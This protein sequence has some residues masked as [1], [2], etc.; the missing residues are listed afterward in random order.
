MTRTL[1]NPTCSANKK[2]YQTLSFRYA[3]S[4]S[5]NFRWCTCG[6]GQVHAGGVEQPIITCL[7]CDR[8]SCFHH[9]GAWHENLTCDE[10]DALLADPVNFRSRFDLENEAAEQEAAKRRAQ[11]DA[12]RAYAQSLVAREERAEAQARK[13]QARLREQ[14][15]K[16]EAAEQERKRAADA[17]I[18]EAARRRAE[19]DQSL[20][21]VERTSKPC[22]GCGWAIEKNEGW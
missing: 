6:Y 20:R 22:P 12:D 16:E 8:R 1:S 10:Y 17:A 14:Q 4:E 21:L 3:I 11:E 13:E 7:L 18:R 19:E 9:E 2:S 15:R 5:E